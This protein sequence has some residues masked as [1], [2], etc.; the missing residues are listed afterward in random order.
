MEQR[1][2]VERQYAKNRG[3]KRNMMKIWMPR[4]KSCWK[5]FERKRILLEHSLVL[6]WRLRIYSIVYHSSFPHPP[7]YFSCPFFTLRSFNFCSI[8][9]FSSVYI[10]SSFPSFPVSF[11]LFLSQFVHYFFLYFSVIYLFSS[12]FFFSIWKSTNNERYNLWPILTSFRRTPLR[13][14]RWGFS[15]TQT[16]FS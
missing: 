8:T 2:R 3:P 4:F 1:K 14:G 10:S 13:I 16:W 7:F 5:N 12:F 15:D 6:T 11:L 9:S